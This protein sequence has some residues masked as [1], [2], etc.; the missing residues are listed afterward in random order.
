MGRQQA[1]ALDLPLA[2]HHAEPYGDE[3]PMTEEEYGLAHFAMLVVLLSIVLLLDAGARYL[4]KALAPATNPATAGGAERQRELTLLVWRRLQGELTVLACLP[5]LSWISNRCGLLDALADYAMRWP[6]ITSPAAG[7]GA[8]SWLPSFS[9]HPRM[10]PNA[11]SV[12]YLATDVSFA[13]L[14][15]ILLYFPS[16]LTTFPSLLTIFIILSYL[17]TPS[18]RRS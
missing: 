7:T 13:L 5:V 10:P 2:M 14:L 6:R 11:A 8:A 4:T 12:L 3:W 18:K 9:C 17:F 15:T 1:Q 16:S